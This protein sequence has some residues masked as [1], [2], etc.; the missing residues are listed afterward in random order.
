[1]WISISLTKMHIQLRRKVDSRGCGNEAEV[2]TEIGVE[3]LM[4]WKEEMRFD[5]RMVVR[6]VMY[7]SSLN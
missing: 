3:E 4:W 2:A 5:R 7:S 6:L 1:M